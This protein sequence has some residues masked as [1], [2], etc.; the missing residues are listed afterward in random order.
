M[1]EYLHRIF[2]FAVFLV[3]SPCMM[4]S[5]HAQQGVSFPA[6]NECGSRSIVAG[7]GITCAVRTDKV[8]YTNGESVLICFTVTNKGSEPAVMD[9]SSGQQVDF[10]V[11]SS[12]GEVWRASNHAMY[13]QAL[14]SIELQPGEVEEFQ[15]EWPQVNDAGEP[16]SPCI[17]QIAGQLMGNGTPYMGKT[18]VLITDS[19]C[20]DHKD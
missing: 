6:F 14:T 11:E 13:I 18:S 3:I 7:E 10:W 9:F 16:V 4:V 8:Q 17:Y 15:E 20:P 1:K 2:C 19:P 12:G 5:S